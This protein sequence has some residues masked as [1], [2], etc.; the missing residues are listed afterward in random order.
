MSIIIALTIMLLVADSRFPIPDS[1]F[2]IPDSR[3]RVLLVRAIQ[4]PL[5][6]LGKGPSY[7]EKQKP[8]S[9]EN[10]FS[11]LTFVMR[12]TKLPSPP[13]PSSTASHLSTTENKFA[14]LLFHNTK[15]YCERKKK[16]GYFI[17]NRYL[18]NR[19]RA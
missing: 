13:S 16:S 4:E 7:Y 14:L 9:V 6:D 17:I 5:V 2:P 11:L 1:R 19:V 3:F 10:F 15:Q 18:M 8:R 12:N